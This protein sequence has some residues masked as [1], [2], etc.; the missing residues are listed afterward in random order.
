MAKKK[1]NTTSTFKTVG[2]LLS[3]IFI[4]FAIIKAIVGD[5]ERK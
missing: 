1:D 5:I 3:L 4:P 2:C